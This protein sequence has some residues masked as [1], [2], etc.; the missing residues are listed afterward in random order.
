MLLVTNHTLEQG[1]LL[2]M[3]EV[4]HTTLLVDMQ[5]MAAEM[6]ETVAARAVTVAAVVLVVI[7][8]PAAMVVPKEEAQQPVQVVVVL[9]V[10]MAVAQVVVVVQLFSDKELTVNQIPVQEHTKGV[11]EGLRV[12]E[13]IIM[14]LTAGKLMEVGLVQLIQ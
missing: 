4:L 2:E 14:L 6:V 12:A 1:L 7:L 11:V 10:M 13:Q 3:V 5:V 9:V 8:V